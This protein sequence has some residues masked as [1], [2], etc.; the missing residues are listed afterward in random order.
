VNVFDFCKR[1]YASRGT[2][3]FSFFNLLTQRG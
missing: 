3:R 1:F 2:Q